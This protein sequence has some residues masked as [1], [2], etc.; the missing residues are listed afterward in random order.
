MISD[1]KKPTIRGQFEELDDEVNQWSSQ[2]TDEEESK[3]G[4]IPLR[5]IKVATSIE[6]L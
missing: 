1:H 4:Q 3:G 5:V 6:Q 2:R